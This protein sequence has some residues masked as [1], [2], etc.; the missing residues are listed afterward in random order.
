V[1]QK[2]S[3]SIAEF[4]RFGGQLRG[5]SWYSSLSFE[6]Y[7]PDSSR[8]ARDWPTRNSISCYVRCRTLQAV[9]QMPFE[10]EVIDTAVSKSGR[11][12]GGTEANSAPFRGCRSC[13][14]CVTPTAVRIR[15]ILLGQSRKDTI[16]L[17]KIHGLVRHQKDL[18]VSS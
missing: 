4:C 9:S 8:F 12:L 11:L 17:R 3:Y 18:T 10:P 16:L 5:K 7:C 14:G 1:S 13:L 6:E 15:V 2:K